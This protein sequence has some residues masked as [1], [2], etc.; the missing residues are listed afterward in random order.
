VHSVHTELVSGSSTPRRIRYVQVVGC[1]TS[2][3]GGL[4][5]NSAMLALRQPSRCGHQLLESLGI[6]RTHRHVIEHKERFGPTQARS[7]T[8]MATSR[9]YG[10]VAPIW[11]PLELGTTP[12]VEATS[13]DPSSCDVERDMPA[14]PRS[15]EN[16]ERFVLS[17][18]P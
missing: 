18:H 17:T 6:E 12:S 9:T 4:T 13:T 16:S 2:R 15:A 14:K 10:V 7:S 8:S 3:V 1:M 11:R 5:T